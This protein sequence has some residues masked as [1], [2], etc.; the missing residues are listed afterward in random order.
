[1]SSRIDEL[2]TEICMLAPQEQQKLLIRV[3]DLNFEHGLEGLS[4]RYRKRLAEEG[5]LEQKA[6]EVLSEL[7]EVRT[8]IAADEY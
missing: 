2:A 4:A 8:K 1:M 3:A 5:K 7:E 6:A